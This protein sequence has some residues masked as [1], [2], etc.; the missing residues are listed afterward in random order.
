MNNQFD[1]SGYGITFFR[2]GTSQGLK[3]RGIFFFI[4]FTV[5]I[6]IESCYW[7]FANSVKPIILGMPFGMFFIVL[8]IILEFCALLV[9]YY[10]ESEDIDPEGGIG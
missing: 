5:I 8:F 3:A 7:L 4:L 9:L 1:K 6:L 10:L 2:P